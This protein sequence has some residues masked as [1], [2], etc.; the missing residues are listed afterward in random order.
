MKKHGLRSSVRAVSRQQKRGVIQR[1]H[2]PND[3]PE[4]SNHTQRLCP[5]QTRVDTLNYQP[6]DQCKMP[7]ANPDSY[8][9]MDSNSCP[10]AVKSPSRTDLLTQLPPSGQGR[11]GGRLGVSFC[12]SRREPRLEP[13]AS[14][15][16]DLEEEEKEKR[17]QM[18][19]RIR[20]IMADIDRENGTVEE[21]QN[22]RGE[23]C[24][25]GPTGFGGSEMTSVTGGTVREEEVTEKTD[26]LKGHSHHSLLSPLHTQQTLWDRAQ[27]EPKMDTEETDSEM[28][29]QS[30]TEVSSKD[31]QHLSVLGKDGSSQLRWPVSSLKFTKCQPH[32]SYSCNPVHLNLP[33]PEQLSADQQGALQNYSCALPDKSNPHM[34]EISPSDSHTCLQ[35]QTRHDVKALE[36]KITGQNFKTEQHIDVRTKAHLFPQKSPP[37]SETRL[38]QG[39]CDLIMENSVSIA[40]HPFDPVNSD[41]SDTNSQ[42]PLEGRLGVVKGIRERA[43]TA[44]SCKLESVTQSCTQGTYISPT[45]CECRSETTC[46]CACTPPPKMGV[47]KVS[48]RKRR[49]GTKK[50]K[51]GKKKRKE[52]DKSSKESQSKR[53]KMRSVVSTVSNVK[54]GSG[55]TG[56][57]DQK[58]R[59]RETWETGMRWSVQRPGS[60][61]LQGRPEAEPASYSA[62]ARRPHGSHNADSDSHPDIEK[63]TARHSTDRDTEGEG[64]QDGIPESFPWRS[65]F[66][67]HSLS[68]GCN[69]KL[70]WER[71][72][73]SNPGSFMDSRYA[74]NSCCNSPVRN[75]TYLHKDR[76]FLKGRKR[77]SQE[78]DVWEERTRKMVG[79]SDGRDRCFIDTGQWEWM[80]GNGIKGSKVDR[81]RTGWRSRN[82]EVKRDPV[83]RV[84]LSPDSWGRRSRHLSTE[85]TDWDRCSVDRWTW[86][87]SDSWEDRRAHRST[88]D[89]RTWADSRDGVGCVWR[90]P[91][92]RHPSSRHFSSPE[93]WTSRQTYSPLRETTARGSRCHS[94]RSCSPCSSTSI[95][96]L[97]WEWSRSSTCSGAAPDRQP[98]NSYRGSV[99]PPELSTEPEQEAKKQHSSS[100]PQ[101]TSGSLS[102]SSSLSSCDASAVLGS[103]I[104]DA[105]SL[106][107]QEKVNSQSDHTATPTASDITSSQGSTS[108]ALFPN[109]TLPQKQDRMLLLPIIGKLPAIQRK[110]RRK[111]WLLEKSQDK[112]G[113]EEKEPK[114][115]GVDPGEVINRPKH[116]LDVAQSGS[117]SLPNPCP[118][119]IRTDDK[120]TGADTALPI[121]F[122]AE[123]LDKYRLLQERAREHMQKVLEQTQESADPH[124]GT[125]CSQTAHTG[126]HYTAAS[127][128]LHNHS[129]PQS[130]SVPTDAIPAQAQ[131]THQGGLPLPHMPPQESFTQPMGVHNLPRLP[132]SPLQH[133]M[134]Q[135]TGLSMP[136]LSSSPPSTSPTSPALHPHPIPMLH[137]SFPHHLHL[138]PFSITSLLPSILLSHQH[139]SLLPQSAAFHAA[140]LAPLSP[141]ALQPLNPQPFLER[142]WP[143]RFQQKAL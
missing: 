137:S 135:H 34:T 24:K 58:R 51:Q 92:T 32:I 112:E 126:E 105:N 99:G 43:I 72:H 22:T 38:E 121:S 77:C 118:T 59:Q 123:E 140:P 113:D 57:W 119:Q 8:P 107:Q 13:S 10:H 66:S 4:P 35:G 91:S 5:S 88:S 28:E 68:Q 131:R 124:A 83:V 11:V 42:N 56:S 29:I 61:S 15:F 142:L 39:G 80:R 128:T 23:N 37:S 64:R 50:Y 86:G 1:D 102:H 139:I 122:S 101:L 55:S 143:V 25:S 9:V 54:D 81:S 65:H 94:P 89:S 141:V 75:R 71:G 130:Q 30:E 69:T 19:E 21:S 98:I 47:S 6:R 76:E 41:S 82:R 106:R 27:A 125:N 134:V 18:K 103:R 62:R 136:P 63:F 26:N 40:S 79:Y 45:R 70:F 100:S 85:D 78:Y 132:S 2:S 60:S 96:E 108:S 31:T 93:W 12:F 36:Q 138:S 114:G 49:A 84:S 17:E 87:S 48:R 44:L 20:E 67:L 95:S 133:F 97:S 46:E 7:S 3:R 117:I 115:V 120:L 14:V 90:C 109:K 74:D 129:L 116:S 111:K 110:T 73:Y 53:C 127:V 52:E 33:R 104:C 16:S